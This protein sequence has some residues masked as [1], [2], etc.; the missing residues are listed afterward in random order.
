MKLNETTQDYLTGKKFSN[1]LTVNY[2]YHQPI[3]DRVRFLTE[4]SRGKRILHLGCL[5]HLPLIDAKVSSHQWLHKELTSAATRCLGVDINHEAMVYV[6]EKYGFDNIVERD[7]TGPVIPEVI[8]HSWDFAILGEL[9]EHINNP[10]AYLSEIREKYSGSID[11]VIITV[12][13]VLTERSFRAAKKSSEII[14][15]DH[16]YWFTPYTLTKV[17]IE[18]G[19]EPEE[20]FFANRIPLTI[21]ELIQRK[22]ITLLGKE[23]RYRF[24]YASS[25]VAIAKLKP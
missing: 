12:P 18:S 19:M 14:N 4:L 13:N 24:T 5:D 17:V 10:V 6:K 23:P 22:L 8:N 9:L 16:R 25:I 15:T 20:L 3:P 1:G 21:P 2:H 11:K 7:I